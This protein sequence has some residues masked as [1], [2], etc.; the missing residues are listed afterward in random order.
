VTDWT[1]PADVERRLRRRW[2]SGELLR[3]WGAGEPW[4][5]VGI[6]LRGPTAGE[7]AAELAAA[8]RWAASWDRAKYLRVERKRVGGRLIG[9]NELPAKAWVDSYPELWA[10]LGVTDQVDG[11]GRL[12]AHTR[13]Q[14]PRLLDW[15]LAHPLRVLDHGPAWPALVATVRWID[16][17][18][19]PP[20]Y[21]RQVDVP[22]VN[23]KFIERHQ[24]TLAALL[25]LQLDPARIDSTRPR[26][27]F[28]AR[29]GFRRPPSHVRLRPLDPE[30]P[31]P[32]GYTELMIRR[33]ELAVAPPVHGTVHVVENKITYLAFPPAPDAVAIFGEGYAVPILADQRWLAGRRLIY[34]GDIDTH[35]FAI[36][37]RLRQRFGHVRSL[38]M[39]RATLLA[40]EA[41]WVR[42]PDPVATHLAHLDPAESDLYRDL[43]EDT[44]GPAVRLEQE[45]ISYPAIE[46]ALH[47]GSSSRACS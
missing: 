32:G 45:R 34:S 6:G 41:Q 16:A 8:Q 20:A 9:S 44:F 46:H 15:I 30:R 42:E 17:L 23:T 3:R 4:E 5:P 10:F 33:D 36:L 1:T 31:L 12:L 27:E 21:L 35:G 39:D 7:A 47:K 22:G 29:Y 26:S 37:D 19:G 24:A 40:H 13:E 43:V 25:D 11:F 18:A 38:L 28:A 14:A 2:D